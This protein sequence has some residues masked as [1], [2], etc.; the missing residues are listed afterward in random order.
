[1]KQYTVSIPDDKNEFFLELVKSLGFVEL[2]SADFDPDNIE[3]PQW[4][5]DLVRERV[6]T[7]TEESMKNW[8]DIKD[9]FRLQ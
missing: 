5:I 4:H 8:D 6:A 7:S 3:I 2:I 1:M 9:K